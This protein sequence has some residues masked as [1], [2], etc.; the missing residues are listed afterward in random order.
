MSNSTI[1]VIDDSTTIRKMVHSHL[2][3]EGYR[4]V[5]APTGEIGVELASE[6]QPD[7][8]LLDHQLPGTT[9]IEVCKKIIAKPECSHIP[10]V[11]SS[12]LRKQAYVEY[13]DVPN[14]VD[15]L[16]KPFKPGL[17]QMTM[18]H[19]L[20]HGAPILP[21]QPSGTAVYPSQP[22]TGFAAGFDDQHA[23]IRIRLCRAVVFWH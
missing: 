4:V 15:S 11:V 8:I 20:E 5:L 3:Q 14:V 22:P 19:A 13:M 10:F 17:Q 12:T 6:V 1:L 9:G 18:A 16:P 21:T 7:L 23:D 2:S